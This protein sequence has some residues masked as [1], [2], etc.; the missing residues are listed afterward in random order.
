MRSEEAFVCQA[1]VDFLGGPSVA[2]GSDGDDPPDIDLTI[3]GSRVGMEVTRLSQFTFEPDEALG[4]RK[5]QDSFG[6]RLIE[7]LNTKLGALLPE[8]VS[9]VIVLR[10][11][12]PRAAR[13]R[14]KV[15]DWVTQ[16][17]AAASPGT[18]HE[19]NLEGSNVSVS[20]IPK[21]PSGKKIV[22]FVVNKHS[23]ADIRLNAHLVLEDRIQTKS[24][25]CES[26]AATGRPIWLAVL[27]DYPLADADTYAAAYRQ[28]K[29]SHCFERLFLVSDDGA[30]SEL[31]TGT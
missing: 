31:V 19:R 3:D 21:R 22:G 30:V 13:F 6:C 23:S 9:L 4:N 10:V 17:V 8:N 24:K 20:V 25:R 15:T 7:D 1:L 2:S 12:V 18:K 26:L 29:I 5:T 14:K 28:L 27:N 16:L 11:P